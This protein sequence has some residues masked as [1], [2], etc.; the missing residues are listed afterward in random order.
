MLI[1]I[2]TY[3]SYCGLVF[4]DVDFR[5]LKFIFKLNLN[6]PISNLVEV[7]FLMFKIR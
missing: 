5:S 3:V 6:Q 4:F 7:I 2:N 1:S